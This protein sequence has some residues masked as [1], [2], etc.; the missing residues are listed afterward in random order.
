MKM[1][2]L[3][4]KTS[5]WQRRVWHALMLFPTAQREVRIGNGIRRKHGILEIRK[6]R[7]KLVDV[8][9]FA[10]N[11]LTLEHTSMKA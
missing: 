2:T 10:R 5:M 4:F 9:K 1:L 6:G 11:E 7:C 3:G 8:D